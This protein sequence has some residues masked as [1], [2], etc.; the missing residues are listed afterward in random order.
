MGGGEMESGGDGEWV[1][2]GVVDITTRSSL[3]VLS[4]QFCH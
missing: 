2:K 1:S 3:I 4:S